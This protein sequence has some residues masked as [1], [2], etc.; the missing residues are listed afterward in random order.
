MAALGVAEIM[1]ATNPP[2]L[3]G[4]RHR[5]H[6]PGRGEWKAA[7]GIGWQH[8]KIPDPPDGLTAASR[9]AWRTWFR[10]WF[11]AYWGPEDLPVLL[12]LIKFYDHV[13]RGGASAADKGEL[14][15]WLDGYGISKKGQQDRR[16]LAP[17]NAPASPALVSSPY[18]HL[19]AVN[20]GES[21]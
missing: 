5:H 15:R 1:A 14:R 11:A 10:S 16:W 7:P 9:V 8:G 4:Q 21:A 6:A 19:R 12:Q 18:R 2:K 3:P 13:A 20:D 17:S